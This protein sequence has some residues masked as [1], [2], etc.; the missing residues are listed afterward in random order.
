MDVQNSSI[1]HTRRPKLPFLMKSEYII[2]M[3]NFMTQYNIGK[4]KSDRR[5]DNLSRKLKNV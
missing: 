3:K 4:S 2:F 1:L 5:A